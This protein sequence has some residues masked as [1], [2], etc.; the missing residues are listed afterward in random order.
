MGQS[1]ASIKHKR[2]VLEA[3]SGLQLAAI[4]Y[5]SIGGHFLAARGPGQNQLGTERKDKITPVQV[6]FNAWAFGAG[7]QCEAHGVAENE[8]VGLANDVGYH[9]PNYV[10]VHQKLGGIGPIQNRNGHLLGWPQEISRI[11]FGEVA[12]TGNARDAHIMELIA[13]LGVERKSGQGGLPGAVGRAGLLVSAGNVAGVERRESL[14]DAANR[15]GGCILGGIS[16]ADV[17]DRRYLYCRRG[18]IRTGFGRLPQ[19]LHLGDV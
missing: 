10:G 3:I 2:L 5:V 8:R 4:Q 16:H 18:V 13:R 12:R 1:W 9:G 15:H 17:L 19:R 7:W 14:G 6:G 11:D